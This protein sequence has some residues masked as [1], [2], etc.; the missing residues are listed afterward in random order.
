MA[1]RSPSKAPAEPRSRSRVE[2]RGSKVPTGEAR[3]PVQIHN[4]CRRLRFN[5]REVAAA[6]HLL[7]A[8]ASEILGS[9]HAGHRPPALGRRP[10]SFDPRRLTV[11][12]LPPG[13]LSLAFLTDSALAALHDRFLGDAAATDV[14]TFGGNP[15]LG[16]AGEICVSVD[17]AR[18]YARR[19]GRD[20]SGE[21]T[22]YVVHGWLH[23][24]GHD[25]LNPRAKRRMR[26]AERRAM[27]LL[28][29]AGAAPRFSPA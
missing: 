5:R 11:L 17:A 25:D 27:N 14:I 7:D 1:R 2:R 26:S 13:E 20:F 18:V 15:A 16:K 24:A 12:R 21:L 10:P 8:H 23:L 22:L 19:H 3:R 6:I 28:H 4:G 9:A 29:A